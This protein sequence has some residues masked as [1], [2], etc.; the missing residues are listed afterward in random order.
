MTFMELLKTAIDW[1]KAEVFSTSFFILFAILFMLASGCF[2][3]LGKTEIARAYILP[4]A[5][6]GILLFIIGAGLVY[7]NQ[8]RISQ[9]E[10]ANKED[11]TAFLASEIERA[12]RTL[13][14]Y[15]TVV[16]T[17]IPIIIAACA[18]LLVFFHSPK[19][20][21]SLI[22]SMAM[23]IVILLIDGTA[24]GR[25]KAYYKHLIQMEK[26]QLTPSTEKTPTKNK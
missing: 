12:D 24:Q 3:Q 2:W 7:T 13:Q 21:A 22:T 11:M 25:I 18:L 4:T 16:F 19:W 20:K 9:F 10:K 8:T 1:A 23:L 14:E 5:I 26:S 15:K 17:A 6:A